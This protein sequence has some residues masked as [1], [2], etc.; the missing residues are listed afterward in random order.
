MDAMGWASSAMAAAQ[1]R[2]DIAAENL[3]N[4]SSTGYRRR[5]A[6]GSLTGHGVAVTARRT[7]AR[8]DP[9]TEMIDVLGAQRAFESAAKVATTIDQAR[10][11]S[12]DAGRVR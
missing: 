11:E 3:S 2:L 10:K 5:E 6:T 9:V 1:S 8:V 7:A 4:T 12:A